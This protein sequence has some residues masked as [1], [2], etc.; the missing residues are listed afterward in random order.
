VFTARY[1]LTLYVQ[2]RFISVFTLLYVPFLP[3]SIL[4]SLY[5]IM[6]G[7]GGNIIRK[8]GIVFLCI[9]FNAT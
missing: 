4:A 5:T 2:F 1:G 9:M 8:V 7:V 6:L 3:F